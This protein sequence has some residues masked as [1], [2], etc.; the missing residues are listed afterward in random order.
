VPKNLTRIVRSRS[1]RNGTRIARVVLHTTEGHNRPGVSD[2]TGL[3]SFFD[4]A[5]ASSHLGIDAEGNCI[6][7]VPDAEKAW[8]QAAYNPG[9]LSIEQVGFASTS[10]KEWIQGYHLGLY[11]TAVAL[12]HWHRK[13][14]QISLSHG[15]NGVCQHSNL[16]AAGGGHH[17]CG[18]GYPER[19]VALW[20]RLVYYRITGRRRSP[21]AAVYKAAVLGVQRA[22]GMK[23]DSQPWS[24]K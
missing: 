16:G 8:T 23:P 14:P 1:S 18:D 7:M 20:A 17:D 4:N 2:L 3:A 10:R 13:Y 15:L 5:Q 11:R 21:R 19:Y 6:R 24:V 9:S 12:A 22:Y